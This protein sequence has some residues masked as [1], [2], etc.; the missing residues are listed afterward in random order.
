MRNE[1]FHN[2]GSESGPCPSVCGQSPMVPGLSEPLDGQCC[3]NDPVQSPGCPLSAVQSVEYDGF[4][5]MTLQSIPDENS[6]PI[7]SAARSAS[8]SANVQLINTTNAKII[9]DRRS[10]LKVEALQIT[11]YDQYGR[12]GLKT[13]SAFPYD[14]RFMITQGKCCSGRISKL[15]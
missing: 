11:Y 4:L 5:C 2:C 14:Q 8:G 1:C 3:S 13:C 7:I 9:P 15:N 10:I 12:Q 6:A